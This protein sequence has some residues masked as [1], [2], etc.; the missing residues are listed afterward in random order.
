MSDADENSPLPTPLEREIDRVCDL[1]EDAFNFRD[2]PEAVATGI[3]VIWPDLDSSVSNKIVEAHGVVT[4]TF[5]YC[6]TMP[7][8][9]FLSFAKRMRSSHYRPIRFRPY[10]QRCAAL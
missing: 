2:K 5:A 3:R 8:S 10:R 9:Q 7:L 4:P 6:Q 1:F